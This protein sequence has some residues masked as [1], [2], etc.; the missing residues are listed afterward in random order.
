[1]GKINVPVNITQTTVI[2]GSNPLCSKNRNTINGRIEG[3]FL[4]AYSDLNNNYDIREV[5]GTNDW[6]DEVALSVTGKNTIIVGGYHTLPEGIMLITL[7]K[8]IVSVF[9]TE[10]NH[11]VIWAKKTSNYLYYVTTAA[12]LIKTTTSGSVLF[13]KQLNAGAASYKCIERNGHI[14][15]LERKNSNYIFSKYNLEGSNLFRKYANYSF[16]PLNTL[17]CI[18]SMDER[19]LLETDTQY[20]DM[21]HKRNV[22]TV[23]T[24]PSYNSND[25]LH[26]VFIIGGS[27]VKLP[28]F[29][30][31]GG[32]MYM[33]VKKASETILYDG[34]YV[35]LVRASKSEI[36][37]GSRE[38]GSLVFVDKNNIQNY[39]TRFVP[40]IHTHDA[41]LFVLPKKKI[42]LY[43]GIEDVCFLSF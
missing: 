29:K 27:V 43:K 8:R 25:F 13:S 35:F 21:D 2:D 6:E 30:N 4:D 10:K 15:C 34:Y 19:I 37:Y 7:N 1:M 20:F 39:E 28:F 32:G 22:T 11:R 24:K 12:E 42:A 9:Y 23:M 18:D 41:R 16:E 33:Y 5:I 40:Y 31:Q 14:Y 26:S 36:D 3:V 17:F 38:M